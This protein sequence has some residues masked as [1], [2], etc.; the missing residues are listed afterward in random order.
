MPKESSSCEEKRIL[1]MGKHHRIMENEKVANTE[2]G[3]TQGEAGVTEPNG[4]V[5]LWTRGSDQQITAQQSGRARYALSCEG[6]WLY[7]LF[8]LS[9][10]QI[11][12]VI[13]YVLSS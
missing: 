2:V 5:H 6:I 13:I 3:S 1:T 12:L 9:Q 4:R 8:L 11:F 7:W 10:F